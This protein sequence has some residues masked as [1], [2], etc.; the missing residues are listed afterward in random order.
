M[1]ANHSFAAPESADELL[2]RADTLSW[3]NRW[4]EARP[5][6]A[7][8]AALF[9]TAH[10]PAKALYA[11]VSEIPADEST[12]AATNILHLTQVLN[13][14][15][16]QDPATKL[17]IL[18]IRGMLETNYDASEA[19]ATWRQVEQLALNQRA[20]M[21]ATRAGGEQGIAAF[22]LGDT[23]TA[24][25][26]VV[27]AWGLSKVE[28]DPA[29]TVR[30]ASVYGAGLIQIHRYKEALGPLNKAIDVANSNP[31]VAYPT[32]A[33]YAKIDALTGLHQYA[34]A[35]QLANA[36]LARLQGTP[37]D[38]HKSQVYLSRGGIEREQGDL[39]AAIADYTEE[40]A[41]S[42]RIE[43]YRGIVNGGGNWPLPTNKP[44]NYLKPALPSTKRSQRIR[45][46]QMSC[47]WF[48]A[49]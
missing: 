21:L 17:R 22:I 37:Y 20:F 6:Y 8:A 26:Q 38:G 5:V 47:T 2:D 9:T 32:I 7:K 34:Q 30:Y 16:G 36:S 40:L 3:T 42:R 1:G 35:L 31:N 29:A 25:T 46:F 24:K 14:P 23:Q 18:T 39:G 43:N 28:H 12:S 4:A 41:I 48:P 15:A 49:T 13:S 10:Q 44:D 19:L 45:G 33:V 11:S 27:K